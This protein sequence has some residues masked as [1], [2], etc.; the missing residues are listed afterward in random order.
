MPG[1]KLWILMQSPST[2]KLCLLLLHTMSHLTKL[3]NATLETAPTAFELR[4]VSHIK[5]KRECYVGDRPIHFDL[6][7]CRTTK[8]LETATLDAVPLFLGLQQCCT[9]KERG[10]TAIDVALTQCSPSMQRTTDDMAPWETPL[11]ARPQTKRYPEKFNPYETVKLISKFCNAWVAV[12]AR[13]S[14]AQ[15][16]PRML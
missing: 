9:P 12:R 16:S 4:T 14:R 1:H 8:K 6:S 3:G 2:M 10:D 11:T 7:K 13:G 5:R 15:D